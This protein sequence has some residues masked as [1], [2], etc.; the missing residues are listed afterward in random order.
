MICPR[1]NTENAVLMVKAPVDDAWEVYLCN[2]CY[3]SWRS[4]ED[5]LINDPQKYDS[6]FKIKTEE[7]PLMIKIP[8][9]PEKKPGR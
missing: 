2:T 1:C 3:F 8:P 9:V 6:K 5:D 4:T 7:I